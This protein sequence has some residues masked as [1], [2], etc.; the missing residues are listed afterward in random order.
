MVFD[1]LGPTDLG[2]KRVQVPTP[3]RRIFARSVATGAGPVEN[4]FNAPSQPCRGFVLLVPNWFE[5]LQDVGCRD[6]GHGEVADQGM[7]VSR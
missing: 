4:F 6:F 3:A 2:Q 5:H 1:E 7:R